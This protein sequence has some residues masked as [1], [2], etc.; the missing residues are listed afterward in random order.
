MALI[1]CN[2][3]FL[4]EEDWNRIDK[5]IHD[6]KDRLKEVYGEVLPEKIEQELPYIVRE[7]F[8]DTLRYI[9]SVNNPVKFAHV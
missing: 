6:I 4:G 2:E 3:I 5:I 8:K 7:T 1:K 9:Y